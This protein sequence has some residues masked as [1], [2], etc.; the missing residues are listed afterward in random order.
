[1]KTINICLVFILFSFSTCNSQNHKQTPINKA[2]K[3][4]KKYIKNWEGFDP[5]D[6]V[7][8]KYSKNF[9]ILHHLKS[10]MNNDKIED[11]LLILEDTTFRVADNKGTDAY[12]VLLFYGLNNGSYKLILQRNNIIPPPSSAGSSDHSYDNLIFENGIFS[13]SSSHLEHGVFTAYTY[14]FV[15]SPDLNSIILSEVDMLKFESPEDETGKRVIKKYPPS[16][17]ISID[18]FDIN[19]F[20]S[21]IN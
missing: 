16:Q 17:R 5:E 12:P 14:C 18:K 3:L 15:Y 7:K 1:M 2:V 9:I 19:T 10:D 13:F 20:N 11:R 8:E 6:Y 21:Q 4:E